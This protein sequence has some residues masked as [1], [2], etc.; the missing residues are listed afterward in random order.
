[1]RVVLLEECPICTDNLQCNVVVGNLGSLH[2]SCDPVNEIYL[3]WGT[4]NPP[5]PPTAITKDFTVDC[6]WCEQ[7][8]ACKVVIAFVVCDDPDALEI[9]LTVQPEEE[10]G[11]R[12]SNCSKDTAI[13]HGSRSVCLECFTAKHEVDTALS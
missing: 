13:L 1:M 4:G 12:C 3:Q 10:E 9:G 6:P 2:A 5:P 7:E 8:L 11:Y